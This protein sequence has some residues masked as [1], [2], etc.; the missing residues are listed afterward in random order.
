MKLF[1]I[2]KSKNKSSKH[3]Q[4]GVI[5]KEQPIKYADPY[6]ILIE[7]KSEEQKKWVIFGSNKFLNEENYGSEE[8]VEIKN[9]GNIET[10]Y[11]S[12]LEEF[13]QIKIKCG[14]IRVQS[15]NSKNICQTMSHHTIRNTSGMYSPN[16]ERRDFP[17]T[18]FLD[19]YQMQTDILD[20]RPVDLFLN[21]E[22]HLSGTIE[23]NSTFAI[24]IFPVEII[25]PFYEKLE[26]TRLSGKNVAPVIVQTSTNK[27]SWLKRLFTKNK[28]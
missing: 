16:Y 2:F 1:N 24:S 18:I 6:V 3:S 14:F 13:S 9:Y 8:N 22:T 12:I 21:N 28:K 26:S 25:S 5:E 20:I 19:A 4:G 27:K 23:P 11:S 10:S 15:D 7:N 17:L